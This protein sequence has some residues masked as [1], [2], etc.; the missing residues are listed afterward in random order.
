LKRYLTLALFAAAGLLLVGN[1]GAAVIKV[2]DLV[3]RA[4]GG[5]EPKVLPRRAFAPIRFQGY[6]DIEAE[7]GGVPAALQQ[8]VLEFDRDGRLSTRGL[9]TCS[10]GQIDEATPQ[11]ARAVCKDSIVGTGH[12]AATI[13]LPGQAPILATSLLTLFNG[14]PQNGDPTVILHAR[15][16][17][18][19]AQTFAVVVPIEPRTGA[20]SYRAT[21]NVPPI[22]G[23]YGA[24]THIDAKI[25]RLYS[26][27]KR[28]LSYVSARCSS[29]ILQTEGRFSF[30]NGTVMSGSVSEPCS[31]R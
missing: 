4:D 1:A 7:G 31:V 11:E 8:A 25:G 20:F 17:V 30:A 3:L 2:G 27:G 22:A 16:T 18:P 23:G 26:V 28:K 12:V 24:L 9:P 6:V 13:A 21:I 15:T 10:V 29:G 5:F 14:L 19:V